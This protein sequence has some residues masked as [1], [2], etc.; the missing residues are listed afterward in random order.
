[1]HVLSLLIVCAVVAPLSVADPATTLRMRAGQQAPVGEVVSVSIEGVSIAAQ[2]GARGTTMVGWDRVAAVEGGAL[3]GEAIPLMPAAD[4]AWRARTRLE[5]GDLVG[6]EPLFEELFGVYTGRQGPTAQVVSAGLLRCRLGRGAQ[7]AAVVPWLAYLSAV[8]TEQQS[9]SPLLTAGGD[10]SEVAIIDTA[11]GLVPALPPMWLSTP[12]LQSLAR[13]KWLTVDPAGGAQSP[14][15]GRAAAMAELYEQAARFEAGLSVVIPET[16]GDDAGLGL[17]REIVVARVGGDMQRQEAR[18]DLAVRIG[19]SPPA[20]VEVWCR[21]GIGRSLLREA[22]REDQ[23]LGAAQLLQL[24][25]QMGTVSPYLT[26]L[27]LAEAA[28]ALV[29]LGDVPGALRLRDELAQDYPGHPALEWD[30]IRGWSAPD[31][32][33]SGEGALP[34]PVAPAEPAPAMP[35]PLTTP[36]GPPG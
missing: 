27:A 26:G 10:P 13:G 12:A 21:A 25:A 31:D 15:T 7:T 24:P 30:R 16:T 9:L 34:G 4:R 2:P 17:V 29:R 11:T 18:R 20:W 23:L 8:G 5:R 32:V 36:G 3:A 6:A 28:V 14:G 19:R 35:L 33:D 22:A 1:M